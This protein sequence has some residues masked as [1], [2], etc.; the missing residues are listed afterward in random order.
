MDINADLGSAA[1]YAQLAGTLLSFGQA[2][3]PGKK[4][5]RADPAARLAA[6]IDFQ[7][8]IWETVAA[9][10]AAVTIAEIGRMS[11]AAGRP[12]GISGRAMDLL[13]VARQNIT[14]VLAASAAV[15][16]VGNPEPRII[17]EQMLAVAGE[18]LDN[19][20]VQSNRRERD[21]HEEKFAQWRMKLGELQK[22]F[23]LATRRDL[24]YTGERLHRYQVWRP[25]VEPW[26]GGW[27]VKP[28]ELEEPTEAD[29]SSR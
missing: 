26:P 2:V 14:H 6:Y 13:D 7:S 19:L 8:S 24:G 9:A 15:R 28:P 23:T 22:D 1:N 17:A 4:R 10:S 21:K 16:L 29:Q 20:P 25:K 11:I 27:P 5:H 12:W 3:P 18:L